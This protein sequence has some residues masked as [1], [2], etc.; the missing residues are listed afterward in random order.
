[1]FKF[2]KKQSP[3]TKAMT[4]DLQRKQEHAI[5]NYYVKKESS[6][7]DVKQDDTKVKNDV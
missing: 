7:K 4:P 6:G 2:R 5:I 3:F 1:M